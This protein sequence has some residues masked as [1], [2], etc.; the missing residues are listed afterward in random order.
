[1]LRGMLCALIL[2]VGTQV[3]A[4]RAEFQANEHT[5]HD[6]TEPAVAMNETGDFIVAW[7]SDTAD[8]RG[9]GVYA[10]YFDA[11]GTPMGEEFQVA[12]EG[13]DVASWSPGVGISADGHA[14]VAWVGVDNGNRD[15]LARLFDRQGRPLTDAFVVNALPD[16]AMQSAPCVSMN[17][18]GNFVVVWASSVSEEQ[19]VRTYVAGRIYNADGSPASEELSVE[20][21]AQAR[22][23]EVAMDDSGRFVVSWIRMGDTFN[24]PYGEYVK[25][26]RFDADGTALGPAVAL[27]GDLNSRWYGPSVAVTPEGDFSIAWAIG[28]FPYDILMQSF[29]SQGTSVTEPYIINTCLDGNQGHPCVAGNGAGEYLVVWDSQKQNG[30]CQDV[31]GQ[32]CNSRGELHGGELALNSYM[33][34]RQWYPDAA[35]AP[36]GTYVVVWTSENQDGSGYGIFGE[37]GA[38]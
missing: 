38:R 31:F 6:Q 37:T 27:T 23:P 12:G 36:D 11:D 30:D 5:A 20:D 35:M 2:V 10:R 15:I 28:P 14:V 9:G 26:R 4:G 18:T 13:V 29:D 21:H 22:W 24:R 17:G 34:D 7:R 25:Y 1:M 32:L 19:V 8:G 3:A 33:A 16:E